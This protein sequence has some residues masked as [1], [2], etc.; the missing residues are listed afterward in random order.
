MPESP[1]AD[2]GS[3]GGV[4]RCEVARSVRDAVNV[5]VMETHVV[6]RPVKGGPAR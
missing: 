3:A 1:L 4:A 6:R 5:K 2:F